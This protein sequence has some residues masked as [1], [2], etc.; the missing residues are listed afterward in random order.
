[1]WNIWTIFMA[2]R[3]HS[4]LNRL[5]IRYC[6]LDWCII[7]EDI[8]LQFLKSWNFWAIVF[9]NIEKI[10][11]F[12]WDSCK[13][14][15]LKR[16]LNHYCKFLDLLSSVLFFIFGVK[17]SNCTIFKNVESEKNVPFFYLGR[18]TLHSVSC[19]LI[20]WR[21]VEESTLF[22]KCSASSP[23]KSRVSKW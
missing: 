22:G 15:S 2:T 20:W 19:W 18:V 9:L 13:H 23:S 3:K 7:K 6:P 14:S 10:H 12:F 1:M 4:S 8:I 11:I 16:S 17:K 21:I 5:Y